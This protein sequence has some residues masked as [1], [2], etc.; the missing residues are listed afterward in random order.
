MLD[1]VICEDNS[2]LLDNYVAMINKIVYENNVNANLKLV[3]TD[4]DEIQTFIRQDSANVFILDIDLKSD[5]TGFQLAQKIREKFKKSYI[6]FISGHLEF[7]FQSFKV[8]PFNF[9]PKPVGYEILESNILDIYKDYLEC[10]DE[11]PQKLLQL[12]LP[13]SMQ[14]LKLSDIVAV[15][16]EE[17]KTILHLKNSRIYCN[18]TLSEIFDLMDDS[19]FVRSHKSFICNKDYIA[20]YRFSRNEILMEN[21]ICCGIGRSFKKGLTGSD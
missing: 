17:T 5:V 21:G 3:T 15:E 11:A 8:R 16:R 10:Q 4:V 18:H 12:K 19:R 20:E 9:L 7:V 14:K 13:G 1:I 2:R 6:I